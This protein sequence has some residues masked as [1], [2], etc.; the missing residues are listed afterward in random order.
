MCTTCVKAEHVQ[1]ETP[2]W[3]GGF[4]RTPR[5]PPVYGPSLTCNKQTVKLVKSSPSRDV[6]QTTLSKTWLHPW[7][8]LLNCIEIVCVLKMMWCVLK[9][10][11]WLQV[12]VVSLVPWLLENFSVLVAGNSMISALVSTM[13]WCLQRQSQAKRRQFLEWLS[14]ID[15]DG[16]PARYPETC[17]VGHTSLPCLQTCCC[18]TPLSVCVS[19]VLLCFILSMW[20]S[21]F[22]HYRAAVLVHGEP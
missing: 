22:D 3:A 9:M 17:K 20:V 4:V 12:A 1:N 14:S 8:H 16:Q 15:T 2:S 5:T 21:C 7:C 11:M 18:R 10:Q 6:V 13:K 19:T